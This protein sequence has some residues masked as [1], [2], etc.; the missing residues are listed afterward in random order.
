MKIK[1]LR[2]YVKN[3]LKTLRN[4]VHERRFNLGKAVA[5]CSYRWCSAEKVMLSKLGRY[6]G[7][8]D[9]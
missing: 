9:G 2:T 6:P 4:A 5:L 1:Y 8:V 3:F 7:P